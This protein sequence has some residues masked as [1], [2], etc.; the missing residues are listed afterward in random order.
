MTK[1]LLLIATLLFSSFS[2]SQITGNV[3]SKKGEPTKRLEK[4]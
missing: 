2:F 4:T 3:S 1:Q